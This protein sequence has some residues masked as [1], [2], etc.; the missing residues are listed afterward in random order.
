MSARPSA[1]R[2]LLLGL[3]LASAIASA[4]A[5]RDERRGIPSASPPTAGSPRSDALAADKADDPQLS[6]RARAAGSGFR[7]ATYNA[8]LAVGVLKYA[9][10]RVQ[11][12][13]QTLSEQPVDLLCVQEFWLE[14]HWKRLTNA[15][16]T[17]LPNTFRLPPDAPEPNGCAEAE[18][19]PLV[20]CALRSCSGLATHEVPYCLARSCPAQFASLSPGCFGCLAASPRKKPEELARACVRSGDPRDQSAAGARSPSGSRAAADPSAFRVYSGSAGTGILTNADIL[21]RDSLTLPSALDRRAVLYT[22]LATP[23]GELHAFCTHLTANLGSVPHPGPSTWQRDQSN[24]VDA[25]LAFIDKKA[26]SKGAVILVGDLNTGPAIGPHIAPSLPSHYQRLVAQGFLNPY[27]SQ[28]DVKCTYCFDN[29]LEGGG[30]TRGLLIDHVLLRGFEGDVAG[31]QM[32]RSE[33]TVDVG[34]RAVRSGFSD[35]YGV[36]VTLSKRGS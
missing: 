8:G 28:R 10:E 1:T 22:K 14:E 21:E 23:V 13:I 36:V 18:V 30:G 29:P 35:H 6:P 27:A 20:Q 19:R 4:V 9:D 3:A 17:A 26:G 15:M 33:L 2:R 24:Q 34:G 12:L 5:C 32:M 16:A 11:P 25:L 7:V 31:A